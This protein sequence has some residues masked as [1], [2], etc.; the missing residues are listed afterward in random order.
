M[1]AM[2]TRFFFELI[3]NDDNEINHFVDSVVVS[4]MQLLPGGVVPPP[5]IKK[6]LVALVPLVPFVALITL[7]AL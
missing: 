5:K 3:K 2:D 7:V 4:D 6:E 1:P